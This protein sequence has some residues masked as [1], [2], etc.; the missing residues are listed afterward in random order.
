M[1]LSPNACYMALCSHDARFD[2]RFYTAVSSTG[3]YCR[4]VCPVKTP[5]YEN[6]TFYR[7]AAEAEAAGYRP[8][9]RCRPELAPGQT[10]LE[11]GGRL[12]V[13]AAAFL[14]DPDH[15]DISLEDLA[16]RLGISSRH[17]RRIFQ[18]AYGVTPAAYRITHRLLSAK[19][20]LTDTRL[21]VT[22]VAMTAG[23]GSLRRFNALFR[24]Q[25]GL[26]P[27]RFRNH[28]HAPGEEDKTFTVALGYRPPLDWD[29]LLG[30]LESRTIEGVEK[31]QDGA[32]YRTV[33]LRVN[34]RLLTGWLKAQP[35][36]DNCR[37]LLTGP[38]T[39]APALPHLI[40]R[41]RRLFDLDCTPEQMAPVLS[42]ADAPLPDLYRPGVRL[43]GC[44]DPFEMAVR[45]VL[46]QQITVKAARTLAGRLATA[47]G[48]P[49]ETPWPELRVLFP[50][51]AALTALPA[52]IGDR[53]GP[54]GVT[55]ARSR[56][57]LA[58]AEALSDDSLE[59]SPLTDPA[60]CRHK[61]MSLPGIGPWTAEYITMRALSWPDAFPHT[62]YG[63]RKALEGRS[64]AE[65]LAL[66]EPYRPWRAYLT[67]LL[68]QSLKT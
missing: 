61:L 68:W 51:A 7:T 39:L 58:L 56:T 57:I 18:E 2:G 1:D 32:Y 38:A 46:G 12:A 34:D 40:A 52:P 37:L 66:A 65:I 17:L 36:A 59:L 49:V 55:G 21:P 10:P 8:C 63:V 5:K 19:M 67:L 35:D 14:E 29:A 13:R 47:Y 45:A 54:L 27:M 48:T 25:Y 15:P 30:F 31:V 26:N 11:A 24:Q 22:E 9:L 41:I 4:P 62:D 43:P 3:I 50:S 44:F 64:D 6:C 33:G 20:L 16:V 42:R 53:L 28:L 60:A 23:F